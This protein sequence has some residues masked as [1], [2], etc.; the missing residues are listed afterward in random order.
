MIKAVLI[1]IQPKYC[2]LIASGKKTI[3]VRKTAPKL[4]TPFKCYIFC[5]SVK[6]M[7]LAKYVEI[8]RATSGRIDD[9]HGK[10]IAEYVCDRIDTMIGLLSKTH[11]PS[12]KEEVERNTCL[13]V[14]EITKYLK[15]K[16]SGFGMGYGWHIT[17]LKIYDKPKELWEFKKAG[18]M[19][20]EQW[21][22]ALY[23]NTHCHYAD[24]AKKFELTRPPQSWCYCEE[25]SE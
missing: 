15:P 25:L 1:S 23:P 5:T 6:N 22:Y 19:T 3:E 10:V 17:D 14:Q 2:E 21:L 16:N 13:T 7:S 8:H 12:D 20:E 9:W 18:Y 11:N 24:W 4:E